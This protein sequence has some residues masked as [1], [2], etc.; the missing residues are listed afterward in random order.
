[1]L[2]SILN[3][4]GPGAS[5]AHG[6]SISLPKESHCNESTQWQHATQ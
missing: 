6:A 1:M 5:N 2:S 4:E 3:E